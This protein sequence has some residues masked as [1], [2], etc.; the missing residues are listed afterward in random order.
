MAIRSYGLSGSGI[1]VEQLVKDMMA[2]RRTQYDKVWQKK[3]QLEWKKADYNTMYTSLRDFRNT[4]AFNY[5]LQSTLMPKIASSTAEG[6]VSATANAEAANV[7]HTINVT[8]LAE[9]ARMTS[10]ISLG[11]QSLKDTLRNQFA[12]DGATPDTFDIKLSNGTESQ[13]ITVDTT[14]SINE[15]VS[16]INNSGL[17]IKA[18]YDANLD[19]FFIYS[20]KSGAEAKIDFTGTTDID[21][22]DFLTSTLKLQ[23]SVEGKD[24]IFDFDGVLGLSQSSNTFTISGVTYN[25]KAKGVANVVIAADNE[26]SLSVVKD[27]VNSYNDLLAKLNGELNEAKYTKF[28]PLTNEERSALKESEITEWDKK[29]KSGMLR[30]DT[31]LQ[32]AVFKLRSD[33]SSPISGLTGNYV[34]L[35]SIGI[36]TGNYSEGGKLY[37]DEI[38]L[39]KA[40]EEDPD[41]INKLF[42]TSGDTS[43]K[44]GV[45]NR[46][47]D[48]IKTSMDKIFTVAG[49]SSTLDG[50][51]KSS[52]AMR[53]RD[54]ND[55]LD[56]MN[57]RL[58]SIEARYYKQFDAMESAL[59]KISQQN[60]WLL[61][62]FTGQ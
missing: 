52:L 49:I 34:S 5:K 50:D 23:T 20:T 58:A 1:D 13:T 30:R 61:S 9:G 45:S 18:N 38:K 57:D 26:K 48:T 2:A 4:T 11:S 31:I 56:R 32:E 27:F 60:S 33:I 17:G 41:V 16:N 35:A 22:L 40:L 28:M 43:D 39:K 46:I 19:R 14:K 10:S 24:A 51:T 25:L 62:Q 29:S 12:M 8:Q 53:I 42:S 55:S 36:T 54:Y 59:S 47:Y 15:F 44:Q 37:I 7:S 3:T 21:G 6:I